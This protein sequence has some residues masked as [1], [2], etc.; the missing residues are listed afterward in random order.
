MGDISLPNISPQTIEMFI[1]GMKK[2]SNATK[3]MRLTHLKARINEAI[4]DGLVKYDVHLFVYTKMSKPAVKLLDITV[5]DFN[6]IKGLATR[7]KALSL[8]KGYKSNCA[9]LIKKN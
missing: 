2:L 3:Q 4:E 9:D 5:D 1:L 7:H 8:A 6:K